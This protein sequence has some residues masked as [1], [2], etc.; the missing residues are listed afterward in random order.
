MSTPSMEIAETAANDG[1]VRRD[2]QPSLSLVLGLLFIVI[3]LVLHRKVYQW[4]APAPGR[5]ATFE[6]LVLL[7]SA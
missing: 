1:P 5:R 3:G 2:D 7:V 4:G 6:K